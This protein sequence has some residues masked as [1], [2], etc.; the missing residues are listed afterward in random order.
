MNKR[1]IAAVFQGICCVALALTLAAC[2]TI[3]PYTGEAKTSNATKGA[4]IGAAAGAVVG[5]ISGDDNKER[6]RRAAIGAG[7]G[8]LAG[9][10]VG[11]YM[12]QQE[13]KLRAQLAG[14]GVSVTRQGDSII[15]NMPGNITFATNQSAINASF[16]PVLDSVALVLEEYEKTLVEVVGHTDS[17]GSDAINQPLSEQRGASVGAYLKSRGVIPQRLAT[18]GVGSRYP[19]AS[20]DTAEGRALNR[21]VEITLEPITG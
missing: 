19:V 20:N 9:A 1:G 5:A 16:Y 18:F 3:D 11:H 4:A 12:D 13:A 2:Q 14:T 6:R 15:L 21:R 10:G 8:A 17:T 7:I